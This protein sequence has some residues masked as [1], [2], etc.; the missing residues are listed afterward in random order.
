[1]LSE[2]EVAVKRQRLAAVPDDPPRPPRARAIAMGGAPARPAVP[3]AARGPPAALRDGGGG[4]SGLHGGVHAAPLDAE[5]ELEG[6]E[7]REEWEDGQCDEEGGVEEEGVEGV[8]EEEYVL[9]EEGVEDEDEDGSAGG[10]LGFRPHDD[11]DLDEY[12]LNEYV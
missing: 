1:M 11:R 5:A 3:A 7:S 4:G 10:R 2:A 6:A 12:V 8:E 9:V